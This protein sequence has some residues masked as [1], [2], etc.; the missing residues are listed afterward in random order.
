MKD[1]RSLLDEAD[2]LR[3]EPELSEADATRMRSVVVNAARQPSRPSP[4]WSGALALAAAH[5]RPAG[6]RHG[7]A[8]AGDRAR[9]RAVR[10]AARHGD[11]GGHHVG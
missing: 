4:F 5:R 11:A 6:Q 2:P 1:I 8:A 9:Y 3:R 7:C 10:Q